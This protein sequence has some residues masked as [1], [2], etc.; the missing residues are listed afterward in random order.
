MNCVGVAVS[1]KNLKYKQNHQNGQYVAL[2]LVIFLY[3]NY[4]F[5]SRLIV[6]VG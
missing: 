4:I 3:N 5:I 2:V 1:G 6:F